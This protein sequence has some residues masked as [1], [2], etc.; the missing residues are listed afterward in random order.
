MKIRYTQSEVLKLQKL[1]EDSVQF[2]SNSYFINLPKGFSLNKM[3]DRC[4]E[5]S[6]HLFEDGSDLNMS[7]Q[8]QMK[9]APMLAN[10]EYDHHSA[11]HN[12]LPSFSLHALDAYLQEESLAPTYIYDV[13]FFAYTELAL[14]LLLSSNHQ[15]Q[16][17]PEEHSFHQPSHDIRCII[18]QEA[19][20]FVNGGVLHHDRN[21]LP[22][23]LPVIGQ[24]MGQHE[25]IYYPYHQRPNMHELNYD[26]IDP[27]LRPTQNHSH[28]LQ[29]ADSTTASPSTQHASPVLSDSPK[30]RC[31]SPLTTSPASQ[32]NQAESGF[33][34]PAGFTAINPAMDPSKL[35]PSE[36][37]ESCLCSKC[38]AAVVE[39]D[40]V[41]EDSCKTEIDTSTGALLQKASRTQGKKRG[42][43]APKG[44]SKTT[45]RDLPKSQI[46]ASATKSSRSSTSQNPKPSARTKLFNDKL[47]AVNGIII[48]S[49]L[50]PGTLPIKHKSMASPDAHLTML[51]PRC[52]G[53]FG[54][55]DHVKSHFAACVGRNGNPG[56]LR[57]DDGLPSGK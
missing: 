25:Y 57:W 13:S 10:R 47:A 18:A 55:R 2:P 43:R 54:K 53:A 9:L 46:G 26:A 39:N 56:G 32:G 48:P 5:E 29:P 14:C 15:P 37:S 44:I 8:Q 27:Q 30:T 35:A 51:C 21:G 50:L 36:C 33:A 3:S 40:D 4:L 17:P 45:R 6:S 12:T 31:T 49:K 24:R 1:L 16:F 28:P 20:N 38:C 42:R 22:L 41:Q 7:Q 34:H 19:L 52:K 23:L 11:H